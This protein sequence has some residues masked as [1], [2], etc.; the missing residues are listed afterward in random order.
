MPA[1]DEAS[2]LDNYTLATLEAELGAVTEAEIWDYLADYDRTALVEMGTQVASSRIVTDCTRDYGRAVT[3]LRRATPAQMDLL[4]PGIRHLV[5]SGVSAARRCEALERELIAGK[6]AST[7]KQSEARQAMKTL[8]DRGRAERQLLH[9]RLRMVIAGDARLNS[10]LE[11][12]Y[13]TA[14]AAD[15]LA[16]SL[17][18]LVKLCHRLLRSRKEPV[19][20]RLAAAGLTAARLAVTGS[21]ADE[22]EN[23]GAEAASVR[24]ETPVTQADL[25]L[26]DGTNLVLYELIKDHFEA[27]RSFDPAIPRLMPLALRG[28]FGR[29]PRRRKPADAPAGDSSNS[30]PAEA[31]DR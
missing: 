19:V 26:W 12:A 3:F 18:N 20:R 13:G 9:V 21:L 16:L 25:D 23:A 22:V 28:Y 6:S 17:R 8:I 29:A 7:S 27:A 1:A 10:T 2:T 30:P 24:A 11:D 5:R 4:S 31:E 15:E 14:G